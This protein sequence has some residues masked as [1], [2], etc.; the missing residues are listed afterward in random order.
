MPKSVN[1]SQPIYFWR[2]SDSHTGWLSQW[3]YFPFKD[4][5]DPEVVYDTAEHYMMYQKAI[6]F[7]DHIT[8]AQIIQPSLHPRKIKALGRQVANFSE[9]TWNANR[10]AIVRRGNYLKFTNAVTEEGFC[11]G[12]SS[13]GIPLIK[14]SLRVTLLGTGEREL[15]EASP[16]DRIWGVG[17]K[18]AD[19]GAN[20][21]RWGLNL[22]GKALMDVRAMFRE[23]SESKVQEE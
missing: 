6:L 20:R 23:E 2:E 10:E 22:L 15:V 18:P 19:A 14:G 17:F 1:Q 9:A 4:D 12:T 11:L 7:N 5:K 8:A 16:F 13:D 3:Y 21:R